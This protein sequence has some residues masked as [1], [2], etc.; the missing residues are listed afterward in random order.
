[1][2]SNIRVKRICQHCGEEFIAKRTNTKYCSHKCNSTAYKLKRK[3]EKIHNSNNETDLIK[4]GKTHHTECKTIKPDL[5]IQKEFLSVNEAAELIGCTRQSVYKMINSG[6][7]KAT[8]LLVKKTV[9]K[10][11]EIDKM[12]E[13]TIQA[14]LTE[15][16]F[17]KEDCYYMEELSVLYGIAS[18]TVYSIIKRYKIDKVQSGAFAYV[19][20]KEI[21]KV[22]GEPEK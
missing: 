20:K 1:M 17:K 13:Q 9:I 15:T 5:S 14:K 16:T 19:L 3:N 11:S 6:R 10:R 18:K 4:S 8:N 2:N 21:H 12:F 22:L 7:L